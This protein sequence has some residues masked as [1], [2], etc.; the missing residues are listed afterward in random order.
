VAEGHPQD[1]G[2]AQ[3]LCDERAA[4]AREVGVEQHERGIRPTRPAQMVVG[5]QRRTGALLRSALIAGPRYPR[6]PSVRIHT[7]QR[8]QR[9]EGSPEEVF[10]FFADARNLEAIT[11]PPLHFEILTPKI[12]IEMRVGDVHP[13]PAAA[14]R[15]PRPVGHDDP[16]V[17][18]AASLRRR[19]GAR[20]VRAVHHTHTFATAPD[21]GTVMTDTVRYAIGFGP[22]GELAHRALVRRDLEAIFDFRAARVPALLA[23]DGTSASPSKMRFTPGRSPGEPA[24]W[25]KTTVGVGAGDDERAVRHPARLEVGAER[26]CRLPLGLEVRQLLD[27]DALVAAE[28]ALR[29]HG[30]RRDAV[31]LGAAGADV[32]GGL[33]VDRQLVRADLAER[34]GIEDQ[35]GVR[36]SRS[37]RVKSPPSSRPQPELRRGRPGRD[38][39]HE[40][41]LRRPSSRTSAR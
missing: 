15:P 20:A 26:A 18:A 4:R 10:P 9:L 39:A 21:G 8:E 27:A 40:R 23:G 37:S 31:D 12:P 11:P 1:A 36:P 3:P 19:P 41:Y 7:L 24:R 6:R 30:V 16:G 2:L 33:L 13:I 5:A 34:E 38:D 28:G 25:L 35:D 32:A 29:L 22:L 14:A 17:G